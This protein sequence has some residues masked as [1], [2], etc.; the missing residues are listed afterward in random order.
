M[1]TLQVHDMDDRLY[2]FLKVSAKLQ[3]RS[4]SREVITIIQDY[5][6]S[7]RNSTRNATLEFI[8]LTGAWKDEKSAEKIIAD[9]KSGR[10]KSNRFGAKNIIKSHFNRIDD[11][12]LENWEQS[13][14][15]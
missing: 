7:P 12:L 11:L 15:V 5:L 6:N 13:R 1:A 10:K 9:I 14:P 4:I 2:N 8:S 3:N